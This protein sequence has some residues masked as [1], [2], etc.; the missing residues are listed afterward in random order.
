MKIYFL[1]HGETDWNQL[2]K[3][4][5]QIDNPLNEKGRSQATQAAHLFANHLFTHAY[6]STLSRAIETTQIMLG[7]R[8]LSIVQDARLIERDFG[9]LE[10][11]HHL[12]YYEYEEANTMPESVETKD[13]IFQRV[14]AFFQE[15]TQKHKSDDILLVVA[16]A[17]AIRT[18]TEKMFPTEFLFSTRLY[19]CQG[20]EIDYVDGKFFLR[21]ITEQIK[22]EEV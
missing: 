18:W 5:G 16:H 6:T 19:N 17:H 10:G 15:I 4:Q 9:A 13:A 8:T 21:G 7:K 3:I 2:E 22:M 11:A 14:H 20:V 1:R 12:K